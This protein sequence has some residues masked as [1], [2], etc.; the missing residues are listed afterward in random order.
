MDDPEAR[1]R[2]LLQTEEAKI[3]DVMASFDFD[4]LS[5]KL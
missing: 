3:D 2:A 5:K 4:S 1:L